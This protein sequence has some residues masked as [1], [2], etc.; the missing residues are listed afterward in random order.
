MRI[1]KRVEQSL[2]QLDRNGYVIQAHVVELTTT[3]LE[4][5][6][7]GVSLHLEIAGKEIPIKVVLESNEDDEEK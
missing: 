7:E 6:E 3:L 5:L 4:L 1:R 2:N